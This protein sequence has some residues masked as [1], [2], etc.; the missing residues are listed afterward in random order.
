M[1]CQRASVSRSAAMREEE[2]SLQ[3]VE[4]VGALIGLSDFRAWLKTAM[5]RDGWWQ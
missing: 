2:E 3:I 5:V 4:A 1:E